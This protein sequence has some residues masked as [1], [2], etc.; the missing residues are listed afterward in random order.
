MAAEIIHETDASPTV[1]VVS[2]G[3]VVTM[4]GRREILVGGAIAIVGSV[5]SDVGS[6][7][8]L[9][10]QYPDAEALDAS[11]C[12]VTPGLINAHQH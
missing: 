9:L 10:A 12:S 4:N 6:S 2:G 8:D 3:D 7:T 5:I 1:K 11:G